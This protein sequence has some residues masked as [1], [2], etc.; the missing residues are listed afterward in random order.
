MKHKLSAYMADLL[1]YL[2][3][4]LVAPPVLMSKVWKFGQLSS[5]PAYPCP[6]CHGNIPTTILPLCMAYGF[7]ALLG[8]PHLP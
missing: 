5:F 8:D 1:F 4:P 3:N 6:S 2:L 7:F